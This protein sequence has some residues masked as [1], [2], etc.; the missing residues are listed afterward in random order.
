MAELEDGCDVTAVS[1]EIYMSAKIEQL[2]DTVVKI[3]RMV[4]E[5]R[6]GGINPVQTKI[7]CDDIHDLAIKHAQP[8]LVRFLET[9]DNRMADR[10]SKS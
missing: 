10:V 4:S 8:G 9:K 1:P 6:P 3:W 7:L 2:E 5:F